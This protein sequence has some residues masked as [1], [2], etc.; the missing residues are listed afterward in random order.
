MT[1]KVR[2]EGVVVVARQEKE[3]CRVSSRYVASR[4]GVR[5][6][7]RQFFREAI[8][9]CCAASVR[10]YVVDDQQAGVRISL[11]EYFISTALLAFLRCRSK[12]VLYLAA[13]QDWRG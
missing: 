10:L 1:S 13:T 8:H 5:A 2:Y 7:E 11:N 12:A 6:A 4:L 9:P 3:G